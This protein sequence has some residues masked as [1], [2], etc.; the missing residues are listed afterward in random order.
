[1]RVLLLLRGSAGVG[2]STWIE[3]NG[4][5]QYSL[6]ADEIRMMYS[7]PMQMSNGKYG[8]SQDRDR[9]VWD[10]LFNILEDRMSRGEFTVIDATNSKTSEMTRYKD[11]AQEYRY[12]IYCVDF[13]DVPIEETKR[14]NML[15][16]E[17]KQVPEE[18]ID[19]MYSRFVTQKVPA[20]IKVIKPN[21]LDTIFMN[22]FDLSEYEHIHIIGDIHGCY[23]ALKYYLKDE[24]KDNH[25]YIFLGDY[26]DRGIENADVVKF[27]ISIK[28]KK[29]VMLLEGNHEILLNKYANDSV[30]NSKEFELITK[31]QLNDSGISKKDIRQ[32][33][34][35]LAQCA[36]FTYKDKTFLVTHGGLATIP[37]K[38]TFIPTRQMIHG[39][40]QF[41]DF[42]VIANTWIN[43][44][45]NNFYQ[46]HG[47][48]NTK[49]L[50]IFVNERVM[51]LEGGI[52]YGGN[53]RCVDITPEEIYETYTPNPVFKIP[54][55][56]QKELLTGDIGEVIIALRNNK[57]IQEKEFGHI[58]SFNFTKQAFYDKEWN[59]QTITARGLYVDTER[60]KIVARG[61]KK[62]FNINERDDTKLESLQRKLQFPVTA[63]VKENGYLGLISYDVK[64]DE[65]I[66]TT[67]S[68]MD[69]EN[70][71]WFKELVYKALSTEQVQKIKDFVKEYDSTLAFEVI[72]IDNDPHIIEYEDSKI[73][74]LDVIKNS[75]DFHKLD[76]DAMCHIA[77][78]IGLE[79]KVKAYEIATWQ[80]FYDWYY[81][82]IENDY[83]YNDTN[84]EGFVIEDSTGHMVKVKLAYYNFWKFMR[85]ISHETIRKGYTMK[86]SALTTPLAN[87]YY[88]W[89]KKFFDYEDKSNIP[90]DIVNL[91]R[92]FYEE[93]V[94]KAFEKVN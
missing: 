86:T 34:R 11:L 26:I 90:M 66:I 57:Y 5:K 53:L 44:T 81:E 25:F 73:V 13:T 20:S 21:E 60:G 29:N 36:Y 23:T 67:K 12:R 85:S 94:A 75:L 14:R 3:E 40:G 93:K 79:H 35:K 6:S 10:T 92:M 58:S 37:N 9:V 82:V 42:E 61:Y 39:V 7:S 30:T 48:R 28:D 22:P 32:L 47:H 74:L 31:K 16:P 8:I 83:H 56:K 19:K 69:G 77:N 46:I 38:L 76:Y 41:K 27:L 15:R 33:Y 91:R 65:L 55:E 49:D 71:M 87:E 89:V 54:D 80:E 72:D 62:F 63:Y 68:A 4:L 59:E 43:T 24:I 64:T 70:S 50:P 78:K 1:M 2:K 17:I 51:N 18:V 84:I 52:E 88:S 45:P